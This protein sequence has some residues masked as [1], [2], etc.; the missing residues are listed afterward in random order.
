[1]N[2]SANHKEASFSLFEA[3]IALSLLT[4][5]TLEVAGV[6]GNAIIFS[7]Y[8]RKIDQATWLA[9]RILSQIEYHAGTME[10]KELELE[11]K[12]TP[13]EDFPDFSY[14]INIKEWKF[15]IMDLL[16]GNFGKKEGEEDDTA[17]N[18]MAGMG[19]MLKTAVTQV[20][21]DTVLKTAN[22]QVSWADGARRNSTELTILLT[23]QRDLDKFIGSMKAVVD[24]QKKEQ[25]EP[26][27]D[28]TLKPP[29]KKPL[30]PTGGDK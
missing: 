18:P 14:A 2:N 13:F 12:E 8:A 22:V 6:Q 7:D 10:L 5:L 16:T 4:F 9:K 20:F 11:V 24:M 30:V 17:A 21:N 26:K 15:P 29:V 28:S 1:M 23:N 25:Q 19:D 27:K 3:I